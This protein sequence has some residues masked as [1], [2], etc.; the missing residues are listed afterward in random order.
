VD[1]DEL[2]EQEAEAF[3]DTISKNVERVREEKGMT[4]LDVSRELGFL[5]PDHYSRMELRANGK[6]FNLKHL[7][8]LSKIL[9]V[10]VSEFIVMESK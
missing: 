10:E 3:L 1:Q 4:K 8:K 7:Y 9:N 5:A 2:L 6:H